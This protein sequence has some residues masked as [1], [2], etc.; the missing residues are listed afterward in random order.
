MTKKKNVARDLYRK[1]P[2]LLGPATEKA[3]QPGGTLTPA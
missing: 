1:A 2:R 3:L